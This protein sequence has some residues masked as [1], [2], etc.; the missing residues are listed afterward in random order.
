M[1]FTGELPRDVLLLSDGS[2]YFVGIKGVGMTALA[3]LLAQAGVKVSGADTTESFVT[4]A[5]LAAVGIEVQPFENAALGDAKIVVYSGAHKGFSQPLVV[6]ARSR[7]LVCLTHAQA[8][9]LLSQEKETIGVC[10]VGGKSTVSALLSH[11][12]SEAGR[13]PSYAVGVGTIPNLGSSGRWQSETSEFVVEADEYVADPLHDITPR[14]LYLRP[15]HAIATSLR[16]D[17]PDVYQS[18][19]DTKQAF[20]SFFSLL[21][22]VGFLVLNGDD[23]GL[24][25]SAVELPAQVITVG[26]N[27]GNDVRITFLPPR[28]GK[29]GVQLLAP[30]LECNGWELNMSIPGEHN[31]R[32]AAF[33]AVLCSVLGVEEEVVVRAVSTFL[34][35]PRRFEYR[36]KNSQG[37]Q[38]YDDYAHHPH[39]LKAVSEALTS[40]F[41]PSNLVL[42]FQPHTYSRTKALQSEFVDVLAEFPGEVILLPIFAS[43][44]ES[45]DPSVN[46]QQLV[47]EIL[48]KG[49]KARLA[50]T[51]AELVEYFQALPNN[52]VAMTA[53]AGDIYKVYDTLDLSLTE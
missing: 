38:F 36:G 53:G 3:V 2:V 50:K 33:A 29:G 6:E 21:P 40:W 48:A 10:G 19:Q 37:A 45:D 34:S 32:N 39:E 42:A 16:F 8:I 12:L 23:S 43:A 52:T 20:R 51:P 15:T 18:L 35:T 24:L 4:D 44:R 9:G 13:S 27:E 25:E 22:E 11:I 26:E 5:Q 41:A 28:S 49:G 31:L 46:S 14:F 17:H 47:E 7:G 1:N 30:G